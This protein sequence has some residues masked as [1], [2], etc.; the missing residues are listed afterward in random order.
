MKTPR[1]LA[2]AISDLEVKLTLD[3]EKIKEIV[4]LEIY[5][6]VFNGYEP[7]TNKIVQALKSHA[8]ELIVGEK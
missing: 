4:H 8:N 2:Q 7:V 6:S 5:G 3:E 1:E